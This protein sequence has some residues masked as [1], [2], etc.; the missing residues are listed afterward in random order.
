MSEKTDVS[1]HTRKEDVLC[2]R[3]DCPDNT[4]NEQEDLP[5]D[6]DLQHRDQC[7]CDSQNLE[8]F[9]SLEHVSPTVSTLTSSISSLSKENSDK[10]LSQRKVNTVLLTPKNDIEFTMT[11]GKEIQVGGFTSSGRNEEFSNSKMSDVLLRHFPTEDLTYQLIDSETIPEISFTDSF[12]E[13]VLIKNKSSENTGIFS[14]EEEIKYS[15]RKVSCN[16]IVKNWDLTQDKLSLTDEGALVCNSKYSNMDDSQFLIQKE[17]GRLNE[18]L[19]YTSTHKEYQNQQYFLD[20]TENFHSSQCNEH[21]VY[22]RLG[23][24]SEI[25]PKVK[26]LKRNN[27]SFVFKR[28]KS[29]TDLLGKDVL[30][31][32]TFLESDTIRNQD[33]QNGTFELDQQLEVLTRQAEVQNH[34]DQLRFGSKIPPCSNSHIAE[35]SIEAQSTGIASKMS[36]FSPATIPIEHMFDFSQAPHS[37]SPSKNITSSLPLVDAVRQPSVNTPLLQNITDDTEQILKKQ[38]EELKVEIFS[39]CIKQNVF[40]VQEHL[41]FL[42]LLKEQL[43]QLEHNYVATKE[44]HYALQLQNHNHSSRTI[45]KFDPNRKVEGEIFKLGMFLEDIKEKI[46]KTFASY[47]STYVTSPSLRS[48]PSP[49]CSSYS[50]SP[51]ITSTNESPK[52][53]VAELNISQNENYWKNKNHPIEGTLQKAYKKSIQ[54]DSNHPFQQMNLND[55]Q[56]RSSALA[57]LISKESNEVD[58][59]LPNE[60]GRSASDNVEKVRHST[61]KS[62]IIIHPTLKM[63][64]SRN[65][66]CSCYSNR[67]KTE[68]RKATR[69]H[70]DCERFPIFFEG[71]PV[72][73]D[74]TGSLRK[75]SLAHQRIYK[76]Q[77]EDFIDKYCDRQNLYIPQTHYSK[78]HDTVILSP[79]YL[80]GSNINGRKSVSN[81]RKRQSKDINSTILNCTLDNAIQMAN[82]LK[83]TTEHMMQAVSEDLAKIKIQTLSNGTA[84]QY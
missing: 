7:S 56:K 68:Y 42:Q 51:L 25:S 59:T 44:K 77:R 14:P 71:K 50:A 40:S 79:Q 78:M 83:T 10:Q 33:D 47:S 62:K 45:G 66:I 15:E 27:E 34:I 1:Q 60:Q 69:G 80:S 3:S 65:K 57:N 72:D 23:N 55:L 74:V 58:F 18:D 26:E 38:T 2:S 16:S 5:Y 61:D 73:L 35:F 49:I 67:N 39:E 30:E 37:E 43:E 17:P 9:I 76:E 19:N 20:N 4:D 29:S 70:S 63:Q 28:T 36:A 41:Q 52:R 11:T 81:R 22:Y 13:T 84:H 21:Q 75:N 8:E 6:G 82:N 12:D 64:L 24:S 53:N 48:H 31:A 46:E 54:G 32:I